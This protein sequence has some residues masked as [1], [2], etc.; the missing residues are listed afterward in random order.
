MIGSIRRECL[1]HIIVSNEASL[2][3]ILQSYLD[4]YD[5]SRLHLHLGFYV[6]WEDPA[7]ASACMSWNH[8][9]SELLRPYSGGRIYANYMSA[10]GEAA[11]K[12]VYGANFSRL[13]QLKKKYDPHNFF[14]L[15]QNVLPS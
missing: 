15:N 11:A 2:R 6:E 4:V 14:H 10:K 3:R 1:D 7:R 5:R 9:T 8:N 12:A 13:S